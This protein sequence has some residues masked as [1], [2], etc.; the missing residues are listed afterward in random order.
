MAFSAVRRNGDLPP[1]KEVCDLQLMERYEDLRAQATGKRIG[2]TTGLGLALFLR[3]GM[4]AWM[5]AWSDCRLSATASPPGPRAEHTVI[6]P[7]T[8]HTQVA[9][10]LA[11]MALHGRQ[12]VHP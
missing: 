10:L 12:E 9:L 8:L 6:L 4:P 7:Q 5:A 2:E 1:L 11:G 3:R